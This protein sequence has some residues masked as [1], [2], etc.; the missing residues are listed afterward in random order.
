MFCFLYDC[1]VV[2]MVTNKSKI[3]FSVT[4]KLFACAN[5]KCIASFFFTYLYFHHFIDLFHE[6]KIMF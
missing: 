6:S 1:N 2:T 5:C 3:F 4:L